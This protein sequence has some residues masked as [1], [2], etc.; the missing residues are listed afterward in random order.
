MAEP[1]TLLE[2]NYKA[3]RRNA[4]GILWGVWLLQ[5][6]EAKTLSPLKEYSLS[7]HQV[8]FTHSLLSY[9]PDPS[10]SYRKL[11]RL[12]LF[13]A[14]IMVVQQER[15]IQG[16]N[17]GSLGRDT[18]PPSVGREVVRESV[19]EGVKM[20]PLRMNINLKGR[21]VHSFDKYVVN[22]CQT[23]FHMLEIQQ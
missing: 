14:R 5:G 9:R 15:H 13:Q 18:H 6:I 16:T 17:R 19:E 8:Q 10:K 20:H 11:T 7:T 23:L 12:T 1:W 4:P 22:I 21:N 3:R 2:E